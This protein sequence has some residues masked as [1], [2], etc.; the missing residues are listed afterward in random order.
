MS[1]LTGPEIRRLAEGNFGVKGERIVIRPFDPAKC[2]PNSYDVHLGDTVAWYVN[3]GGTAL[4]PSDIF[5]PLDPPRLES[6]KIS[7][8]GEVLRPGVLY[9]ASTKEYTETHGLAPK[10]EGRSSLARGGLKVHL[11][12]GFGDDGF[13]GHWTLELEVAHRYRIRAGMKIAQICYT[14]LL[15]DR[16]PYQGRYQG[17]TAA[18]TPSRFHL[19]AP[20]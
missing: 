7:P 5:D 14:T 10:L 19:E 15:G 2:G 3:A 12:A 20:R 9:L 18:P 8:H 1:I 4:G 16:Q 11:T 13:C 6:L 17:Q